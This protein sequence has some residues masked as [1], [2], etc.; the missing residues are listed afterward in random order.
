MRSPSRGAG[1][2]SAYPNI[3]VVYGTLDDGQILEEE[4]SKADIVL[5]WASSD[6]VGA[7]SAIK[8]GLERGVGGYWIH[9]SGTDILLNPEIL[10]G[11]KDKL[12]NGNQ[13]KIYD[14][15]ENVAEVMS[16]PGKNKSPFAYFMILY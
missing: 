5:H 6:H 14:D 1:L 13:V 16:F 4:A 7:A 12:E 3:K 15:W 11:H 8:R 9:I 10:A 2:S